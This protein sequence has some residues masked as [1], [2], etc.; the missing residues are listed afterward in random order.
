MTFDS[1]QYYMMKNHKVMVDPPSGDKYGFPKLIP[2]EELSNIED[3][4]MDN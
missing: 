1:E 2:L 4:L 3:W